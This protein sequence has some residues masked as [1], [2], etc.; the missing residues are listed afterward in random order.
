MTSIPIEKLPK[1]FNA[2]DKF[3]HL[4]AYFVLGIL[5]KMSFTFQKKSVFIRINSSKISLITIILYGVFDELH[6]LIIPGRYC[7][8]FDF[9]FDFIGGAI[10]IILIHY[11]LKRNPVH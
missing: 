8:F 3:E 1:L 11:L 4:A 10:G 9:L 6:Q 7:D 5:L 2:Q